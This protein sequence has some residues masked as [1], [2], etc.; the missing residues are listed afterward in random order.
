MNIYL[1]NKSEIKPGSKIGTIETRSVPAE[2]KIREKFIYVT[3]S[4]HFPTR[5]FLKSENRD[6]F[7]QFYGQTKELIW[8]GFS[9]LYIKFKEELLIL[10]KKS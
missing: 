6:K 5:N 9:T 8:F 3:D 1:K 7:S 4:H 2:Y 10:C